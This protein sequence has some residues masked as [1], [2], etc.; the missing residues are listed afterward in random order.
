MVEL[1]FKAAA[2]HTAHHTLLSRLK[3]PG[4]K[5]AFLIGMRLH[6]ADGACVGLMEQPAIAGAST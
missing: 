1:A 6:L 4:S 5:G 2:N 3:D